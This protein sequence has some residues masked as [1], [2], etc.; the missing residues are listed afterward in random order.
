M[1]NLLSC[2]WF[3]DWVLMI[4]SAPSFFC[5]CRTAVRLALS[6]ASWKACHSC[7][8]TAPAPKSR[9]L[10]SKT[11]KRESLW[12]AWKVWKVLWREFHCPFTHDC[13][14]IARHEY[15][16]IFFAYLLCRKTAWEPV[17][18]LKLRWATFIILFFYIELSKNAGYLVH[19]VK[20]IR[21]QQEEM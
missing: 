20:T 18:Q 5:P 8:C 15:L 17:V 7:R 9:R 21:S 6:S 10:S 11:F 1:K 16:Q 12:V 2:L 13:I 19:L 14:L 3:D 4:N